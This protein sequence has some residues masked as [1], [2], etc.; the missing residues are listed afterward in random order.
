M[1]F[2]LIAAADGCIDSLMPRYRVRFEYVKGSTHFFRIQAKLWT[3]IYIIP[4]IRV[5]QDRMTQFT[6]CTEQQAI[7]YITYIT[8]HSRT[9]CYEIFCNTTQYI[10]MKNTV[11]G[12]MCAIF[13]TASGNLMRMWSSV[14]QSIRPYRSPSPTISSSPSIPPK[15]SF[16]WSPIICMKDS[17]DIPIHKINSTFLN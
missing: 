14:I 8:M 9:Q 16:T 7:H 2:A 5:N 13:S 15:S 11:Q 12:P 10:L 1:S 17:D 3:N 4:V 6:L